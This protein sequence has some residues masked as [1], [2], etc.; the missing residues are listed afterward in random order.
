[1]QVLFGAFM[2]TIFN[3][4][5]LMNWTMSQEEIDLIK[6]AQRGSILAFE[7]LVKKYDRHVVQVAYNMVNNTQ[8]AEDIYREVMVR[9]Y[10]NLHRFAFKS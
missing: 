5:G 4:S 7:S 2:Q 6:E 10:K 3:F 9:V 1:M 8:D